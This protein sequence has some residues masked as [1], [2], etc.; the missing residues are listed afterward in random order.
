MR[1]SRVILL[2]CLAVTGCEGQ[3]FPGQPGGPPL[4]SA[5][6][7]P[8]TGIVNDNSEPQPLNSLPVGAAN[9]SSAPGATQPNYFSWTFGGG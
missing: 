8:G 3:G 7:P 9:I 4:V 5:Q 1:A 6:S 2:A